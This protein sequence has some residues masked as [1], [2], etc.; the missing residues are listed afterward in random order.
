M[1]SFKKFSD[2]HNGSELF[3]LPNAWNAK[4]ALLLEQSGFAAV[5]T[6]SAAVAESLGYSDGEQMP[7]QDYLF[8]VKRIASTVKLPFSVDLEMGY[9]KTSEEIYANVARLAQLG[10][11]GINLEDSRI[12]NS[13]RT[14]QELEVFANKLEHLK[15][16]IVRQHLEVFVNVRCDT[17]L[18]GLHDKQEETIRRAKAYESSG[19][20]GLFLPGIA[21]T[22]D[23]RGAVAST[24]L[25]INV[26][27]F[28]GLPDFD[29]LSAL[30]VK[31]LSLGGFLFDGVY[32][33]I[34]NFS[35]TIRQARSVTPLIESAM[36]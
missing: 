34:R 30:G 5:G 18:L 9:G 8:V 13:V 17:Y 32:K 11:V 16:R 23:I 15:S 35:N 1:S 20:D 25:P 26:M 22:E 36:G 21:R 33:S 4:S 28:P 6:S 19:A 10:V 3:V 14:L 7:F 29:S 12:D 27:G 2:L 24:R 31:R